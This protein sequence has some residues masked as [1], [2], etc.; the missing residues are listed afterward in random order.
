MKLLSYFHHFAETSVVCQ[1]V[2]I[3]DPPN[4]QCG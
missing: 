2:L 3:H 4:D 1:D